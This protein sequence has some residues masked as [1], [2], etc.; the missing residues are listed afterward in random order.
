[1][2][3]YNF[4]IVENGKT[5][6]MSVYAWNILSAHEEVKESYPKGKVIIL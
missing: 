4:K 6:F 1:M 2:K 3:N 5:Y